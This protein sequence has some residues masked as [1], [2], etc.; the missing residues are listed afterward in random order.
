[1]VCERPKG[2]TVAVEDVP[3]PPP[4]GSSSG[5]PFIERDGHLLTPIEVPFFD[6]LRETG[7]TFAVQPWVQGTDGKYRPDFIVFYGGASVVVE[8]D[9]HEFHKTK[10]QRAHDNRKARWFEK[11]GMKSSA[12]RGPRSTPTCTRASKTCSTY[13]GRAR[14]GTERMPRGKADIANTALRIFLPEMGAAYDEERG[15]K[16]YNGSEDFKVVRQFFGERCCYAMPSL[17]RAAPPK[18]T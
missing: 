7:A 9:G 15:L 8:L 2:Q 3:T 13:C 10:E 6:A 14:L 12:T 1:M 5:T 16:P 18:T 4:S 17:R 11:R